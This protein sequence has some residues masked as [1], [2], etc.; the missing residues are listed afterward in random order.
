MDTFIEGNYCATDYYN[1]GGKCHLVLFNGE[2]MGLLQ[3]C[4]RY[5]KNS[6]CADSAKLGMSIQDYHSQM[7]LSA[8]FVGFTLVFLL[9]FLYVLQGR[10]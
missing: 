2:E 9:G 3:R 5:V 6:G 8:N 4:S 1:E 10:R 7:A